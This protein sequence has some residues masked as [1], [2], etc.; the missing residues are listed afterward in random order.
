MATNPFEAPTPGRPGSPSAAVIV[1]GLLTTAS[2]LAVVRQLE[3][4]GVVVMGWYA[5]YVLPVGALLVGICATSGYAIGSWVGGRE[6]SGA[7][8][9]AVVALSVLAY[10]GDQHVDYRADLANQ[11]VSTSELGFLAWYDLVTRSFQWEEHGQVGDALG[12]WGYLLRLGEVVG[13]VGGGLL[14]PAALRARPYCEACQQYH[15]SRAVVTIPAGARPKGW[16]EDRGAWTATHDERRRRGLELANELVAAA[17]VGDAAR[18]RGVVARAGVEPGGDRP[19]RLHERIVV[20]LYHC[21]GC[22]SGFLNLT[23]VSGHGRSTSTRELGGA[24]LAP[25]VVRAIR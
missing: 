16:T 24:P 18:V 5:D 9:G 15:R 8:L 21:R 20:R 1:G 6:I 12:G 19:N 17:Q 22:A 13:F 25:E 2:T 23:L 10:A 14:A 3:L 7:L 4:D 11:G